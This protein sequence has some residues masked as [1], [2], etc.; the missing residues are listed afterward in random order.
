MAMP[1]G[2]M[3]HDMSLTERYA[4][5]YDLP[6]TFDLDAAMAGASLPYR[7]NPEYGARVGLLPRQGTGD[8]VRWFGVEPCYVFH[9][10][11]AYDTATAG[12]SSIVVRHPKMFA[13][14]FSGP[15][16]ATPTFDRWTIDPASG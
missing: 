11:N 8:D 3:I 9:P 6:C 1:G 16:R 2:P 7:W 4:V 10:L 14:D 5:V 13:T 12:W 15:T